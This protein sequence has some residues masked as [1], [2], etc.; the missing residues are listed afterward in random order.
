MYA[1][2]EI[3]PEQTVFLFDI[4]GVLLH[5]AGYKEALRA[6]LD[7]FSREM[8]QEPVALTYDEIAVFDS[9]GMTNEW[10]SGAMCLGAMLVAAAEQSPDSVRASFRET[11]AALRSQE[12]LCPRPDFAAAALEMRAQHPEGV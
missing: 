11:L 10:L 4:D 9:V 2:G 7:Y 5:P 8:G 3:V 1:Q 6:A 12:V